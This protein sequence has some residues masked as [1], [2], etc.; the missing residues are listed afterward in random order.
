MVLYPIQ[1]EDC[2]TQTSKSAYKAVIKRCHSDIKDMSIK[3]G[4]K[5]TFLKSL[6]KL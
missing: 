6:N 2:S 3:A 1:E 4:G 5:G